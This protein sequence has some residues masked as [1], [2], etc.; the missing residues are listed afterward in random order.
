MKEHL[1]LRALIRSI[2]TEEA[3]KDVLGEPDLSSEE[4]R[5][6]EISKLEYS[7][8]ASGGGAMAGSIEPFVINKKNKK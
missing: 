2:I 5:E 1:L 7:A 8:L 4:D 3:E 6:K